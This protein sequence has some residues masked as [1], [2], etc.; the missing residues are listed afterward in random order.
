MAVES[1]TERRVLVC[2]MRQALW[3]QPAFLVRG[4]SRRITIMRFRPA[5]IRVINRRDN[6]LGRHPHCFPLAREEQRKPTPR[7]YL[8]G[9][10]ISENIGSRADRQAVGGAG[11]ARFSALACI[12]AR[13]FSTSLTRISATQ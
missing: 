11:W 2:F 9:S 7:M 3:A 13:H 12:E 10:S 8:T 6:R 5:N 4:S 1:S